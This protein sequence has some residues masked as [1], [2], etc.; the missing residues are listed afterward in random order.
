MTVSLQKG[1]NVNLTKDVA[2]AGGTLRTVT[3]GLGWDART[4]NGDAFDLDASAFVVDD[5]GHVLT[6]QH[7]VFFGNKA[8][9]DGSVVHAGDYRTG[10]G[11]GDDETIVV[12]LSELPPLTDRIVVAV[13]IYEAEKNGQNFGQVRN[14]FVRVV[15]DNGTELARYDLSE[16]YSVETAVIFG[17]L[18]RNGNDWKFRAVGAGYANG[19]TGLCKDHGVN[20]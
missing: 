10:E 6:D 15:D 2:A 3:I 14:A 1:G 19:L 7:F 18:Y 5:T 13:T 8:T 9:P 11:S 16:D 4:T 17:E 12:K 20:V